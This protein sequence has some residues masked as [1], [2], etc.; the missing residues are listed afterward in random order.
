MSPA[1][2]GALETGGDTTTPFTL[3][4]TDAVTMTPSHVSNAELS[5]RQI[6]QPTVA[7][8]PYDE[9]LG[10]SGDH[11]CPAVMICPVEHN[12][13]EDFQAPTRVFKGISNVERPMLKVAVEP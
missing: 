1:A 3:N 7:L 4:V 10:S 2:A 11:H 12:P 8:F 5:S 9:R 13:T 6:R